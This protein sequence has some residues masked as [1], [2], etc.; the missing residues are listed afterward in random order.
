MIPID[1]DRLGSIQSLNGI[2]KL[3]LWHDGTGYGHGWLVDYVAVTDNK[4]GEEAC[5]FIGEYLNDENGGTDEKHL[6]LNKQTVDNRPCRE[7]QFD[8]NESTIPS[9][10]TTGYP[11]SQY[12]Q[13]YRVETKTGIEYHSIQRYILSMINVGHSGLLGLGGAGTNAP[14]FIRIHD[15]NDRISEPIQLKHSLRHKNKF[16]RNQTG[17]EKSN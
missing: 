15:K 11:P 3:E 2:E 13:T 16:E 5:F 7:H 10:E 14:V 17:R 4:T 8:A 6:I 12:A 9:T 1:N